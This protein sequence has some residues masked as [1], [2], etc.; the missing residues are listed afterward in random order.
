MCYIYVF[1]VCNSAFQFCKVHSPCSC[2]CEG[3][4]SDQGVFRLTTNQACVPLIATLLWCMIVIM[5][6]YLFI[7]ISG[8]ISNLSPHINVTYLQRT[9]LEEIHNL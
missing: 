5:S 4:M 2:Y 6:R 9:I 7:T 3:L 8:V 1:Y